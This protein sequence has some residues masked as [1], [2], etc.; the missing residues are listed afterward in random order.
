MTKLSR[1]DVLELMAYDT[2]FGL[3][4]RQEGKLPAAPIRRRTREPVDPMM[5]FAALK[6]QYGK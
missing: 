3:P 5:I 6:N 2:K 1:S 4:D